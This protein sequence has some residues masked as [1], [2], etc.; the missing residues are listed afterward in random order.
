MDRSQPNEYSEEGFWDS[1]ARGFKH[2][3]A[4]VVRPALELYYSMTSPDTPVWAKS[5][6]VGALGYLILPF[7]AVPDF[8]PGVGLGDDVVTMMAAITSLGRYVTPE[9]KN[10][11]Q[12]KA[13]ETFGI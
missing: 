8:I 1:I 13:K 2:T 6:A 4:T 3:G 5:I 7:D 11:A 10:K 12:Q 9:V